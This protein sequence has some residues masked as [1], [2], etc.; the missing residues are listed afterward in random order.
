MGPIA[1]IRVYF[2]KAYSSRT[3]QENLTKFGVKHALG[4]GNQFC[5][6]EGAGP[7]GVRGTGPNRGIKG[8]YFKDYFTRMAQWNVTNF[9]VKHHWGRGINFVYMKVLVPQGREGQ[10]PLGEIRLYVLKITPQECLNRM[11]LNL[12]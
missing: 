8:I 5:I 2:F 9:G 10:G 1:E 11:Y 12:M 4:K 7:Q 3:A 6:D